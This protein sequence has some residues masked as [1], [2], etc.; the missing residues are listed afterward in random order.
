MV[1]LPLSE[2]RVTPGLSSFF[3]ILVDGRLQP[4][5]TAGNGSIHSLESRPGY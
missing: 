1:L 4:T 2:R 5:P 3:R